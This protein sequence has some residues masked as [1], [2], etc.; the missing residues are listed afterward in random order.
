MCLCL[1]ICN[2]AW[3]GMVQFGSY[4]KHSQIEPELYHV[5]VFHV[6]NLR[7]SFLVGNVF[8]DKNKTIEEGTTCCCM[9]RCFPYHGVKTLEIIWSYIYI[10]IHRHIYIYMY[11]VNFENTD[12]QVSC[13]SLTPT[14][15]A[16]VC[17]KALEAR[18]RHPAIWGIAKQ[19][20][21]PHEA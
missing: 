9:S 11:V 21:R 13:Q 16:R 1:W 2:T 4:T 3:E 10:Y 12:W 8:R 15:K 7:R 14:N 20:K 19:L 5:V 18:F 6:C 17:N